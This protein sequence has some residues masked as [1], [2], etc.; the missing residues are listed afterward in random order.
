[1]PNPDEQSLEPTCTS[2]AGQPCNSDS[3]DKCWRHRSCINLES[4]TWMPQDCVE[5][6]YILSDHQNKPTNSTFTYLVQKLVKGRR[7]LR[8]SSDNVFA[9]PVPVSCV[10]TACFVQALRGKPPSSPPQSS[11]SEA[12]SPSKRKRQR[13]EEPLVLDGSDNEDDWIDTDDFQDVTVNES[14]SPKVSEWENDP[15]DDDWFAPMVLDN[16]NNQLLKEALARTRGVYK[17]LF[18][19]MD[20]VRSNQVHEDNEPS[21]CFPLSDDSCQFITEAAKV[22]CRKIPTLFNADKISYVNKKLPELQEFCINNFIRA[23]GARD[24]PFLSH[25]IPLDRLERRDDKFARRD[26]INSLFSRELALLLNLALKS[27]VNKPGFIDA[28][29]DLSLLLLESTSINLFSR[30]KRSAAVRRQM[31]RKVFGTHKS[32]VA[33]KLV[34][35]PIISE[36]LFTKQEADKA[37]SAMGLKNISVGLRNSSNRGSFGKTKSFRKSDSQGA[38]RSEFKQAYSHRGSYGFKGSKGGRG[39]GYRGRGGP[40][41]GRGR[42]ALHRAAGDSSQ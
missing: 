38:S 13:V 37:S 18:R 4:F 39:K 28:L 12:S 21:H 6:T 35:G 2:C 7:S 5:C 31:R 11:T 19:D 8:L 9:T 30:V 24:L 10:D 20:P 3:H 32:G 16:S 36:G 42:G 17:S 29:T 40:R 26:M 41:G 25:S 22:S 15:C 23:D 27:G 1:M 33:A 34:E 14:R